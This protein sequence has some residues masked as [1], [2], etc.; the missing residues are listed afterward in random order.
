MTITF[1]T[2]L[3]ALTAQRY[4][5]IASSNSSS[6]LAKLSSGSRIPQAKDDAAGLAI[7]SKLKA[8]V[9]GLTQASN[10][11]S[12]ATSLLQIADGALSTIGDILVRMKTLATQ[13]SSGQLGNAERSLLNQEYSNLNS[14]IDRIAA[15]SNFN[16]TALLSGST[17]LSTNVNGLTSLNSTNDTTAT[18]LIG[19]GFDSITFSPTFGNGAIKV[20]YVAASRQLT[21][22]DVVNNRTQTITL[23]SSAIAA[24]SL[25]DY[26][27]GNIGVD[28]K[29]NNK[30]NKATDILGQDTAN[31]TATPSAT[32]Y[33]VT[34]SLAATSLVVTSASVFAASF[35]DSDAG[36]F[37]S[38]RFF[39][40]QLIGTTL[41][42]SGAFATTQA[43]NLQIGGRTFSSTTTNS[44]GTTGN[45]DFVYSDGQGNNFTLRVVVGTA[46]TAGNTSGT[47]TIAAGTTGGKIES[48]GVAGA[49]TRPSL[50]SVAES[51]TAG[52]EFDFG[53]VDNARISLDATTN[54]AATLSLVVNGHTF[55]NANTVGGGTTADL[56]TTGI[57]TITLADTN[58]AATA[59][60]ITVQF[61][62][63]RAFT[64]G[65][66]GSF[67][68]ADLG[69]VVGASSTTAATTSFSFKVGTGTTANDSITFALNS[70][71]TTALGTA[72]TDV[73]SATNANTAIGALNSA[74]SAVS[75]RRADVGANQSRLGFA[76]ANISVAIENTT[77]ATSAILD[78]DVSSEIT[79]FT[80]QQVLLQ[81]GISLEAQANQ[82]PSLLLKLIQ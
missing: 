45:K 37:G 58:V 12:Q 55:T 18:N 76:S 22:T 79:K 56:S 30:F 3:S 1:N 57:K 23:G 10:N 33:T 28:I 13:S 6:S 2:N 54:T 80:S 75:S 9:A 74:I 17:T 62:V 48:T 27:F 7:G 24:G 39:G 78:V 8:E 63:T 15:T 41:A 68:L 59:N 36:T 72:G 67:T 20:G 65:D 49:S 26:N 19:D 5:G 64:S 21:V 32:A 61:N 73:T 25:E 66:V 34:N 60:K 44:F 46:A 35:N 40:D 50:V 47:V 31:V 14:E 4:I 53:T 16:G 43:G 11:A 51:A 77:A 81:A 42:F 52:Q 70:A 29:L 38:N 71:T 69:Q 82:Q